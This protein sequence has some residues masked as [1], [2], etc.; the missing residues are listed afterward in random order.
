M[1][2]VIGAPLIWALR[3]MRPRPGQ[4]NVV[5]LTTATSEAEAYLLRE[6]LRNAG[7]RAHL[8]SQSGE[9]NTGY[10]PNEGLSFFPFLIEVWVRD[11]DEERAHRLLR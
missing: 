4:Q 3:L 6:R 8:K 7:I 11:K 10:Y 5:L 1:L 9:M 2:V